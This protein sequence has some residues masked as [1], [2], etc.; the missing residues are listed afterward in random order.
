MNR[1]IVRASAL[2]LAIL[3]ASAAH[4]AGA[5]DSAD[6]TVN[7]TVLNACAIST[8]TLNFG[9]NLKLAVNAGLGTLGTTSDVTADTG[10]TV[11]VVCTSGASATVTAGDGANPADGVRQMASGTDRLAY[12]LY[13]TSGRTELLTGATSIPYTGSG[14][15]ESVTVYGKIAG[16][17]LAAAKAGTYSDTVSLTINYTP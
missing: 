5:T 3:G 13:T 9:S 8:G 6:L 2:L 15:E 11:K 1:S 17:T 4:A 12:D 7:A 14:A 10:S 16:A